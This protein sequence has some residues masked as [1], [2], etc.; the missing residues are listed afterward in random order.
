[1]AKKQ[2]EIW[3]ELIVRCQLFAH[4]WIF[5]T[6][7]CDTRRRSSYVYVL[8]TYFK[9]DSIGLRW[10]IY[11]SYF[12]RGDSIESVTS[13]QLPCRSVGRLFFVQISLGVENVF[14]LCRARSHTRARIHAQRRQRAKDLKRIRRSSSIG[15]ARISSLGL[16]LHT[17]ARPPQ[18]HLCAFHIGVQLL[19]CLEYFRLLHLHSL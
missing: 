5:K 7:L 8:N 1:M 18:P 3:F 4:G 17:R 14:C 6:S 10:A 2:C 13:E 16:L 12:I 19:N 11:L 9:K 15:L